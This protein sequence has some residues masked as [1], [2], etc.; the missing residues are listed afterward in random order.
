MF[1][2]QEYH[3]PLDPAR[4]LELVAA[5]GDSPETVITIH[6]LRRG[7]C[8]TYV[9]GE[10]A[11]FEGAIIQHVDT[12]AEPTGFST[13]PNVLD[14]LLQAVQGRDCISVPMQ[15]VS[16]LGNALTCRM[17][18]RV[19]Y[20]DDIY[21]HLVQPAPPVQH[22]SVKR[23]TLEHV[24]LLEAAPSKLHTGG[25]GSLEALLSEG[26]VAGAVD[27]G[28]CTHLRPLRAAWRHQHCDAGSLAQPWL[29]DRSGSAGR[30]RLAGSRADLGVER[31]CA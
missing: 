30:A 17:G 12:P 9:A 5:L 14:R 26:I 31:W 1:R 29:C 13:D 21:L 4:H 6:H 27:R 28:D 18:V 19:R 24:P 10:P 20:L 22:E 2:L 25:F 3:L 8:R 11:H 7:S 15:C 23:L 16:S